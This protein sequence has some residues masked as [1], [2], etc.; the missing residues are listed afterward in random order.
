[1]KKKI[2]LLILLVN[3]GLSVNAQLLQTFTVKMQPGEDAFLSIKNKKSYSESEAGDVK[4]DLDLA[5]IF[6]KEDAGS[7]IEWYNLN[8][9][10]DKVPVSLRGTATK[11]NSLNFDKLQFDKCKT[12]QDLERMTGY[13]SVNSY[14]HFSILA[15]GNDCD[16]LLN[17]CFVIL[18][19]DGKKH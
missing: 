2:I 10:D 3:I 19:Q 5:L 7:R 17:K 9:K 6:I 13:L 4:A 16:T 11:I 12:T 14:S 1:M 15:N 8:G 18:K